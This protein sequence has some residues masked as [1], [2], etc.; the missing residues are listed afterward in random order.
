MPCSLEVIPSSDSLNMYGPPDASTSFSL[1]GRIT[2][3]IN[4]SSWPLSRRSPTR[5]ILKSLIVT[6]EGRQESITP[7]TGYGAVRLCLVTRE[8]V[9]GAPLQLSNATQGGEKTCIWHFV[10]DLQIPGWLPETSSWGSPS[11]FHGDAGTRYALYASASFFDGEECSSA[12]TAGPSSWMTAI[13][14][15][16][17]LP[18]GGGQTNIVEAPQ[19]PIVVARYVD[20]PRM[21]DS[22]A[23]F[24]MSAFVVDAQRASM[25]S[26]RHGIPPV[27]LSKVRVGALVPSPVSFEGGSF[28][29]ELRV[30]ATDLE[31]GF[32]ARLQLTE[33]N[34]DIE[35]TEFF[36]NTMPRNEIEA[37]KWP[38]PPCSYQPPYLPLRQTHSLASF[39]D[40]GLV[41]TPAH[42]RSTVT[43]TF[44][45][46]PLDQSGLFNV[47]GNT[48]VFV[49]HPSSL[50]ES[51]PE[52]W[53]VLDMHIPIL[54]EPYQSDWA[55]LRGARPSEDTP[56]FTVQHLLHLALRV[57]YT[58]SY[59]I[60][61][62]ERLQFSVPLNFVRATPLHID[63]RIQTLIP[64]LLPPVVA[65]V[66]AGLEQLVGV[67]MGM[68]KGAAY[69]NRLPPY[70]QLFHPNGEEKINWSMQLPLYEPPASSPSTT[71]TIAGLT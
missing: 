55:G 42:F 31:D 44:S 63:P 19:C 28:P 25:E 10:F 2:I 65:H 16:M 37:A 36:R 69:T 49:R 46:L 1:S 59:G 66:G 58:D 5:H 53:Y 27:V 29:I 26:P 54:Q 23:A 70:S 15:C 18:F 56:L 50:P 61:A 34:V 13:T 14:S 30:R 21:E 39:F 51:D 52:D 40:A 24:P 67:G 60:V 4:P 71:S 64:P 62:A 6:F 41:I 43:R 17:T 7:E 9:S 32:R 47:G 48:H 20:P 12:P 8:L 68:N 22:C 11:P 38:V 45:L 57:Q 33:V 3:T 35:Q